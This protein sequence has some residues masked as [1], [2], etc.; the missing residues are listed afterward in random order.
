MSG[1]IS[2]PSDPIWYLQFSDEEIA[3]VVDEATR[4]R[5]YVAAHAYTAESISRAIR[6]GVRTIEH[7]NLIDA[8]TARQV[9]EAGAFVVPTLVTYDAFHRFGREAGA[10]D[11][12]LAKLSEVREKG[13]EAIT[14]CKAAGVRLG[15]GTDLLGSLHHLQR[16]EFIL[17]A[18]VEAPADILR[19]ATSINASLLGMEGK[20]GVISP[21]ALADL[22]VINGNPLEDIALLGAESDA[23]SQ[24]WS[25]G[26][27]IR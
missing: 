21:G 7:G 6:L 8:A 15:F 10:A 22:I 3:A 1:G 16:D 5:R 17:R 26:N 19:S 23:I 4:R 9:A 24:I 20:L 27:L 11:S 2:T 12:T 14:L 18:K 25:R 13:L